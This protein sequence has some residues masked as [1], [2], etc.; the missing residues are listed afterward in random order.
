METI[1][2]QII[3]VKYQSRNDGVHM[4][5]PMAVKGEY[6]GVI[7]CRSSKVATKI[8]FNYL[9]TLHNGEVL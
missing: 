5:L 2:T 9:T 8:H 1:K 6:R 4:N 3:S 7:S